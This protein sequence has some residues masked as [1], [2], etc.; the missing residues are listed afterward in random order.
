[1]YYSEYAGGIAEAPESTPH[2]ATGS[3]LY[4][5]QERRPPGHLVMHKPT[6]ITSYS[7]LKSMLKAQEKKEQAP[8]VNKKK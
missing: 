4:N 5:N 1:M 6:E 7:H 8:Y 2:P 3:R